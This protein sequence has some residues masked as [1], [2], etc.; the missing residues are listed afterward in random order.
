MEG[1]GGNF[2][3]R[4]HD[5]RSIKKPEVTAVTTSSTDPTSTSP[6]T[7]SLSTDEPHNLSCAIIEELPFES[8]PSFEDM[9]CIVCSSLSTMLDS[10]MTLNLHCRL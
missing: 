5:K 8:Y 9:T 3:T 10:G 1:Q 6:T 2:L 4:T 7:P